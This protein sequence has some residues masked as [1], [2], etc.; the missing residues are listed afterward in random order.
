MSLLVLLGDRIGHMHTAIHHVYLI[1]AI[2]D[3]LMMLLC[4]RIAGREITLSCVH[5]PYDY[6]DLA[7]HLLKIDNDCI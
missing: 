7:S 1:Y 2:S 4:G 3:F 6:P 5:Q